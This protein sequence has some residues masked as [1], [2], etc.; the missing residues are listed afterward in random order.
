MDMKAK[1]KRF[2]SALMA[3]AMVFSFIPGFSMTATAAEPDG[4]W[5]DGVTAN[6]SASF[7]GGAGTSD[8]PYLLS[9]VGDLAQLAV[10]VNSGTMTYSGL[11]LK[12]TTDVDLAA[13]YWVPIGNFA[14]SNRR[15]SSLLLNRGA[16]PAADQPHSQ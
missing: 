10:N 6:T 2:L 12:L 9:T 16:P 8:N 3:L 14:P 1:K 7:S 15:T 13:K 11:F 4:L 5:T